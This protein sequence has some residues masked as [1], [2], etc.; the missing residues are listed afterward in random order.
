[1][2]ESDDFILAIKE[3][4]KRRDFLAK[5]GLCEFYKELS[6]HLETAAQSGLVDFFRTQPKDKRDLWLCMKIE[7]SISEKRVVELKK[8]VIEQAPMLDEQYPESKIRK[9]LCVESEPGKSITIKIAPNLFGFFKE[10]TMS[11]QNKAEK[12]LWN[13]RISLVDSFFPMI[14]FVEDDSS[15]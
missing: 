12:L 2:R 3:Y 15:V 4:R 5:A 1:V 14:G 7:F 6:S 10:E 8:F 13:F 9:N 11:P